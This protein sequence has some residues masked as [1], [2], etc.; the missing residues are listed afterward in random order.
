MDW[1]KILEYRGKSEYVGKWV[2]QGEGEW[3]RREGVGDKRG[4]AF[5]KRDIAD[6]VFL[7][8]LV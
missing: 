6:D 4:A 7:S 2:R 5:R 1:K 3:W 8:W